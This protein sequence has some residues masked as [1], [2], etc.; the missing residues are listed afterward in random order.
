MIRPIKEY[1]RLNPTADA[2]CSAACCHIGLGQFA[3]TLTVS[4]RAMGLERSPQTRLFDTQMH[5]LYAGHI[6]EAISSLEDLLKK[7]P[8]H[9]FQ[10]LFEK[11]CVREESDDSAKQKELQQNIP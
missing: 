6:D 7:I 2:Y 9:Q 4:R 8:Q 5:S 3:K 11:C 10:D 1:I